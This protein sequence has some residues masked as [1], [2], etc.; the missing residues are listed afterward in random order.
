MSSWS[1]HS[2]FEIFICRWT[3][4]HESV[5]GNQYMTKSGA[6][7]I[8]II[9][10]GELKKYI[11][12]LKPYY[13]TVV[14]AKVGHYSSTLSSISVA[15]IWHLT[16]MIS[17]TFFESAIICAFQK[18]FASHGHLITVSQ[19]FYFNLIYLHALISNARVHYAHIV[20]LFDWRST[21][22][23]GDN[24]HMGTFRCYLQSLGFIQSKQLPIV[25]GFS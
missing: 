1:L 14:G 3:E 2:F 13:A 18:T 16:L 20:M 12:L 25:V 17:S 19:Y 6:F 4:T 23:D 5:C 15:F 21:Y 7:I 10:P 8:T 22:T 24:R 9:P 11:A